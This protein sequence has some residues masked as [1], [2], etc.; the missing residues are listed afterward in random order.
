MALSRNGSSRALLV[1]LRSLVSSLR[2]GVALTALAVASLLAAC[3]DSSDGAAPPAAPAAPAPEAPAPRVP[4]Q[5]SSATTFATLPAPTGILVGTDSNVAVLSEPTEGTTLVAFAPDGTRQAEERVESTPPDRFAR[6]RLAWLERGPFKGAVLLG[7]GGTL[8]VELEDVEEALEVELAELA[9]LEAADLDAAGAPAQLDLAG[10]RFDDVA[11][12]PGVRAALRPGTEPAFDVFVTGATAAAAGARPFLL[13]VQIASTGSFT[14]RA[15][16][17][18]QAT[19][20]DPEHR[21][22][23]GT[24]IPPSELPFPD[25]PAAVFAALPT[26]ASSSTPARV[27]TLVAVGARYPEET[28]LP[29]TIVTDE[30]APVTLT[31]GGMTSDRGGNL[32]VLVAAGACTPEG[33]AGV[34][35][36]TNAG[37]E[38]GCLPLPA[39]A[40]PGGAYVDVAADKVGDPVYVTNEKGNVILKLPVAAGATTTGPQA[41]ARAIARTASGAV[42]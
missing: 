38:D 1:F 9:A 37:D 32:Y 2:R 25:R 12:V 21:S 29:P 42:R 26:K 6:G 41:A 34:V 10:A 15:L 33:G 31:S 22:G 23:V 30:G 35:T 20:T 3:D 7:R 17:T 24:F 18:T 40:G 11:V 13:R 4:D 14:A 5:P 36:V 19:V 8:H 27:D 39:P 28:A 16:A